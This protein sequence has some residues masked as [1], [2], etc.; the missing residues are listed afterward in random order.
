MEMFLMASVTIL[1]IALLVLAGIGIENYLT[2]K[3]AHR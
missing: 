3:H 1:V 2:R